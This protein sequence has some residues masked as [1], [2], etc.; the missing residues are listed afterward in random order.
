MSFFERL[1]SDYWGTGPHK[2]T[3]QG[4]RAAGPFAYAGSNR[5]ERGNARGWSAGAGLH[6]GPIGN[7]GSADVL[8]A[9]GHFGGWRDEAGRTNA[10]FEADASVARVRQERGHGLGPFG[11]DVGALTA[12]AAGKVNE[13]TATLGAQAN[14]IE[15]AVSAGSDEHNIRLGG[16]V[17]VGLGG[18]LHYGDADKDG[19][20]ELGFGF[21]AGPLSFDVKS[22]LLGHA[23]NG[24][25]RAGRAVGRAGRA[26]GS[27]ASS[28][29][30]RVTSW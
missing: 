30:D 27:A 17:G 21:D 11:F 22:E 28:A 7:G 19:V 20:R 5:D 24:V 6:S 1:H 18:R 4:T 2:E 13:E 15:G 8:Q 9:Q 12:N 25:S 3:P 23:W 29:W 14:L 26:V 10:G 16:A